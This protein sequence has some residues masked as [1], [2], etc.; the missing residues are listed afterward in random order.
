IITQT[1][2]ALIPALFTQQFDRALVIGLGTGNTLRTVAHLPFRRVDAVELAPQVVE[3]ARQWF[4]DVN[5]RV[6]DHD[7]RLKLSV[8][9]GGNFLLLS[10]ERYDMITIEVTSLWVTGEA[11]LYNREFYELCRSHLSE[12][13]VLQ[14]WVALRHLRARALLVV[15]NTAAQV[16]RHVAFVECAHLVP[17]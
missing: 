13:G 15:L 16:F 17:D 10:R 6:F 12:H 8:G 5:D 11:D 7:L 4:S 9:G 1:R 2:F 14:Q 3:A